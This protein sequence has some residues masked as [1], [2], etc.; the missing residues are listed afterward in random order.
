MDGA[1][2]GGEEAR[3]H[4]GS[5]WPQLLIGRCSHRSVGAPLGPGPGGALSSLLLT[6]PAPLCGGRRGIG[7][8]RNVKEAGCA[9]WTRASG[10][11]CVAES[12]WAPH[13]CSHRCGHSLPA[14]VPQMR[15]R[16]VGAAE[17]LV[18]G[19]AAEARGC[20][21]WPRCRGAPQHP[22]PPHAP[23]AS[24]GEAVW[25]Q[26]RL[27]AH[28]LEVWVNSKVH[29]R[30]KADPK[31]PSCPRSQR[32]PF[33]LEASRR[34]RDHQRPSQRGPHSGQEAGPRRPRSLS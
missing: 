31:L 29:A 2:A 3:A 16:A 23:R 34:D 8:A 5:G 32:R 20:P 24:L 17:E 1:P 7:E 22:V 10:G 28:K 19:H 13:I 15:T 21:G 18:R 4:A 12:P 6:A 9:A 25:E 33:S 27:P 30:F 11:Q 26:D 14:S